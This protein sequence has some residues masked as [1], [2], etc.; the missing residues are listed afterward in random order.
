MIK[1]IVLDFDGTIVDSNEI[2][3]EAYFRLFSPSKNAQKIIGTIDRINGTRWEIIRK[4]LVAL[5]AAGEVDFSDLE[6]E[7]KN[8]G[9]EYGKMVKEEIIAGEGIPG[10]FE[11]LWQLKREGFRIHLNSVTPEGPLKEIIDVLI[12]NGDLP[13]LQGV[14]GRKEGIKEEITAKILNFEQI[15]SLEGLKPD[16]VVFVG[17]REIDR[18]TAEI[19][20]CHFIGVE[21]EISEWTKT[22]FPR[23]TDL[24]DLPRMIEEIR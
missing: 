22:D 20:G 3:R 23:V 19:I 10:A 13:E 24:K 16:E 18:K 15:L 1:A 8:R 17:D 11:S 4:I 6:K 2:K 12:K 7:V 14:F 9:L 21:N 5:K